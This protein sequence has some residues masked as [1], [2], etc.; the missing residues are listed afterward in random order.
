MSDCK[1]ASAV[2]KADDASVQGDSVRLFTLDNLGVGVAP[3][4]TSAANQAAPTIAD[5]SPDEL[6][7][8]LKMRANAA[9]QSKREV[10]IWQRKILRLVGYCVYLQGTAAT[11]N[12]DNIIYMCENHLDKN[13]GEDMGY[14]TQDDLDKVYDIFDM[15]NNP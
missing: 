8:V 5:L 12:R 10:A 3:I 13:D 4:A 15:L 9:E 14:P 1:T 2:T 11:V 6:V 7:V